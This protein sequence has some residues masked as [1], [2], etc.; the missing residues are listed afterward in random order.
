MAAA[1]VVFVNR[2]FAPDQSATSRL[3]TDLASRLAGRGIAVCVITSRQRYED[4]GAALPPR[5][6]IGGVH[7]YRVDSATRGRSRLGGRALDYLTFHAAA[8]VE[9]LRRVSQGDVIVAKTDPPLISVTASYVARWKGVALV[10]WLQDIFP[11]VAEALTPDLLPRVLARPLIAARDR[12]LRRAALNIVLSAGMRERLIARGVAPARIKVVPNWADTSAITPR[13][14]ADTLTRRRHALA[15]RFV[16]G[17]SGNLGRAHDFDTL[18]G[19]ARLLRSEPRFA[20]LI[21][22]AGARAEA[23]KQAVAAEG[24]DSFVFQPFQPAAMLGDSLA[25][26]DVHLV[27]LLPALEGLI[28]PS[29]VYGVL[30]AGRPTIFVGDPDGEIAHLLRDHDC[31]VVVR[32]GDS[33]QLA[34]QLRALSDAPAHVERMGTRARE[35][36][37]QRYTAEHAVAEW[38]GVLTD[39]AP[40]AMRRTQ[41]A[42]AAARYT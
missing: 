7:V 30:A 15:A 18:L 42:L 28:V 33:A 38:L 17:Y 6:T 21:T 8:S 26:A 23:L 9:L 2:Y 10:N 24:L 20:F 5:E 14:A 19:A 29:K 40:A 1:K 37:L 22:G 13:P 31:G 41:P 27:S 35:L 34:A 25:A 11:E 4:P 39:I 32:T 16:L 36:A 3:V 12:S